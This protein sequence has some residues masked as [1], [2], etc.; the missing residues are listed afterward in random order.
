MQPEPPRRVAAPAGTQYHEQARNGRQRAWHRLGEFAVVAGLF[1]VAMVLLVGIGM[2]VGQALGFGPAPEDGGDRLLADPLADQALALTGLAL[3]IPAV[4][5]GVLW[6]GRRPPGTVVSVAGRMRWRWLGLCAAVAFA[7]MAVQMGVL[8][9]WEWLAAGDEVFEGDVPGMT[10]LLVGL[11]LFAALV[12]F[13][14]AAEEF[15]FRGW[16]VQFFGGFLR[17]PWPGVC[18]ASVLFALAHGFGGWSGFFLLLY[19]ALWWGWLVLRTGGLEAVIAMHTA[20]NVLSFGLALAL[21]Q[22]ADAGTAADAPW[23]ALVVELVSAPVFCLVI[24]RMARARGI[25]SRRPADPAGAPPEA[26]AAPGLPGLPGAGSGT[27]TGT[28]LPA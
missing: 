3:G 25:A 19:S 20:N 6:C 16:L 28:G 21:G 2:A 22:L 1:L 14:A 12:P 27:G 17:S 26:P 8:V 7:V 18:V 9:L 10:R 23:Q 4:L 24:D 5:L 11:V 13:Q 15:I